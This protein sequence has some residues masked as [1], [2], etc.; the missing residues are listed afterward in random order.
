MANYMLVRHKVRDYSEWKHGYDEHLPKRN[1]AGLTEKLLLQNTQDP[2]EVIALFE[3]A[4]LDK[5][6]AFS[7]SDDLHQTMQQV[8]V[9]DKPDIYFLKE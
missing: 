6:K 9:I 1:Q 3:A 2:N 4:D 5:A 8:G 7:A